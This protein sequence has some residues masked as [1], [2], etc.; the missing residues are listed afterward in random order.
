[1]AN[2][3]RKEALLERH[4]DASPTHFCLI[5]AADDENALPQR[6]QQ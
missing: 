1:V 4:I 6:L 5:H 2:T 3:C